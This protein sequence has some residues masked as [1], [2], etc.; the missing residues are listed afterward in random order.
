MNALRLIGSGL[1]VRNLH[2]DAAPIQYPNCDNY[3]HNYSTNIRTNCDICFFFLQPLSEWTSA[4]VVEWMAA[5]NLYR[6]ADVFKCKDI[7]GSDLVHLDKEKLMVS[8]EWNFPIR[9]L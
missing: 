9:K 4:N 8:N 5:L 3:N 7:K 6:Y 2:T 1:T